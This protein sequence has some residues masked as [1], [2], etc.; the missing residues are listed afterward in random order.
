MCHRDMKIIFMSSVM[1]MNITIL[2]IRVGKMPA[3]MS[4][5]HAGGIYRRLLVFTGI[6]WNLPALT[7][8][9]GF[10]YYSLY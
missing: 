10:C 4:K 6:Y 3:F 9:A 2:N 5:V 8:I 1:I 7:D